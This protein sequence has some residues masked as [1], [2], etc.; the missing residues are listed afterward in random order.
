MRRAIKR[1][2]TI[3]GRLAREIDR[4]ASAMGQAV[5][6]AL[7]EVLDKAQRIV[8]QSA[9]RKRVNGQPKLYAWHAPEVSCISKGKA[10]KPYEFGVKVGIAST[11]KRNLIVGARAFHHNPYDGH[12]LNA[13]MEQATILMQD[14]ARKPETVFVDLG[15]RGVDA[16]NPGVRVVHRGKPKRLTPQETKQ[17]KRRQAIEPIIG[18]LKADHRMGRCH[19][20]G[21]L[22]D[23]LHA[24]LC[25]AGYN[26]KWL[27]RMIARKGVG[28]LW[29]FFLRLKKGAV[30]GL[31]WRAMVRGELKHRSS[32]HQPGWI[33]PAW[34]A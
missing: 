23:R 33:V 31:F 16:D 17:L 14:C 13:Q 15:Y 20:K 34:A 21:E 12:T 24:V 5:R 28:F 32:C 26:I 4:K 2:R 11:H 18:H 30:P 19:L 10:R 25:A 22:G 27:L 29:R 3:V 8:A 7:N 1:Q 6:D 9:Q